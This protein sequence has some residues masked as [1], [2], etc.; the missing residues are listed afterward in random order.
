MALASF[1]RPVQSINLTPRLTPLVL[2]PLEPRK[3]ARSERSDTGDHL[4]TT[5]QDFVNAFASN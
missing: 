4:D 5:F 1:P 2:G 3:T